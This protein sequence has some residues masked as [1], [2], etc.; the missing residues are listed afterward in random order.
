MGCLGLLVRPRVWLNAEE[1]ASKNT[2]ASKVIAMRFKV[3]SP[4]LL[5]I[6]RALVGIVPETGAAV[7]MTHE[8]CDLV[9]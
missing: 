8:H 7:R 2:A 5:L 9:V 6:V 1:G 3:L 4:L